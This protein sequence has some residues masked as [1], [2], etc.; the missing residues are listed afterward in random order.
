MNLSQIFVRD[1]FRID[2]FH[3]NV[4]GGFSLSPQMINRAMKI[5]EFQNLTINLSS[6]EDIFLFK[7][8]TEREVD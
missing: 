2:L 7:T 5:E 1:D 8:M 4:C 6:P 3:S